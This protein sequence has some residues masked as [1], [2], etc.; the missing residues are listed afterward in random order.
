MIPQI[1]I[2]DQTTPSPSPCKVIMNSW[3]NQTSISFLNEESKLLL[4]TFLIN[5]EALYTYIFGINFLPT[6]NFAKIYMGVCDVCACVWCHDKNALI[7]H[8]FCTWNIRF[9]NLI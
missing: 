1:K 3:W 8:K 4:W 2:R 5:E 7:K 9:V 6:V